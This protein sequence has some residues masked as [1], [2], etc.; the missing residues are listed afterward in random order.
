MFKLVADILKSEHFKEKNSTFPHYLGKAEDRPS[1]PTFQHGGHC[2]GSV[3][4]TSCKQTG[5]CSPGPSCPSTPHACASHLTC[6]AHWHYLPSLGGNVNT[7]PEYFQG[8]VSVFSR[9]VDGQCLF[10]ATQVEAPQGP[11]SALVYY[12]CVPG[13]PSRSGDPGN[14]AQGE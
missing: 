3:A 2:W 12:C 13:G 14:G 8:S 5:T 10:T 4:D 7:H 9:S 6:L 11:G 1:S